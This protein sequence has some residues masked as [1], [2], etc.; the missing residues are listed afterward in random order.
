MT[1]LEQLLQAKNISL[2]K[3]IKAIGIK[4]GTQYG[5][6]RRIRGQSLLSKEE[7]ERIK[8]AYLTLTND[9]EGVKT[10]LTGNEKMKLL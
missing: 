1:T 10:I 3:F 9:D 5:W 7:L 4:S 8:A 6:Y 2:Y